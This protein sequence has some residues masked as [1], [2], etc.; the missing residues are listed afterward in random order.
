MAIPFF[1]IYFYYYYYRK[2]LCYVI[3]YM[4]MPKFVLRYY[5]LQGNVCILAANE[6]CVNWTVTLITLL[7]RMLI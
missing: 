4:Y 5:M 7:K 1:I 6:V 3:Y 2:K